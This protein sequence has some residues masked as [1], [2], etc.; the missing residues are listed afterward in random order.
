MVVGGLEFVAAVDIQRADEEEGSRDAE[1]DEVVH[2]EP[3]SCV[4]P[5]DVS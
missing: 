1:I 4:N 2:D 3:S 5:S